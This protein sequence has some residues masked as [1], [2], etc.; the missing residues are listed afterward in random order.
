MITIRYDSDKRIVYHKDNKKAPKQYECNTILIPITQRNKR[1]MNFAQWKE[2]YQDIIDDI[3]ER[4][5]NEIFSIFKYDDALCTFN[6]TNFKESFE[7][8]LYDSSINTYRS[9]R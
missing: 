8:L 1:K 6:T 4:T 3:R 5:L 7:I 9:F 2:K